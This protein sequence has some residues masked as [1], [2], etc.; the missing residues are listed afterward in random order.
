VKKGLL[1]K[2]VV[3]ME[4]QQSSDCLPII[5][6]TDVPTSL[7]TGNFL[8]LFIKFIRPIYTAYYFIYKKFYY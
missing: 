5:K 6:N 3:P 7:A 4:E 1:K 2:N 8:M